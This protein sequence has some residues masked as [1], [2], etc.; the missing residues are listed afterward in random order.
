MFED[1]TARQPWQAVV[2]KAA[3]D[4]LREE[5]GTSHYRRYDWSLMDK[6]TTPPAIEGYWKAVQK[7]PLPQL[8]IENSGKVLF[9]GPE[10]QTPEAFFALWKQY[11]TSAFAAT[12]VLSRNPQTQAV[13][14]LRV[15]VPLF[16][17]I[18]KARFL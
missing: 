2:D 3:E 11:G 14:R 15:R 16:R 4:S 8:V 6:D 10:P 5:D 7:K 1:V 18:R 17:I 13:F 12:A 9:A